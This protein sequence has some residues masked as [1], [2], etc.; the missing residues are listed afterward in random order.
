MQDA[1]VRSLLNEI[2]EIALPLML[3]VAELEDGYLLWGGDDRYIGIFMETA[4]NLSKSGKLR[5]YIETEVAISKLTS[6][7][8]GIADAE[9]GTKG[10][11]EGG[12]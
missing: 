10:S 12:V 3:G 4:K 11:S 9:N 6:G 8:K 2:S 5:E 1:G 7:A